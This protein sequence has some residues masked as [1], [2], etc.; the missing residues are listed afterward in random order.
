MISAK[1]GIDLANLVSNDFHQAGWWEMVG[2]FSIVVCWTKLDV[3]L[4]IH[5][6]E[7]ITWSSTSNIYQHFEPT[8]KVTQAWNKQAFRACMALLSEKEKLEEFVS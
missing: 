1:D 2:I 5:N 4:N 3:C 7:G 6:L 8:S